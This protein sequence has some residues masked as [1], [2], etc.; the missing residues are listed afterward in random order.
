[1]VLAENYRHLAHN[2]NMTASTKNITV[3]VSEKSY[4]RARIWA[5]NHNISLSRLVE[6]F[7]STVDISKTAL[8]CI[9]YTSDQ[10]ELVR[11]LD[12]GK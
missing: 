6:A 7:L 2:L 4:R 9:G 3:T 10:A 5:A 1:V 12:E 8:Q 11:R